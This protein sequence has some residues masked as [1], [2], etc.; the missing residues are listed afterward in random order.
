MSGADSFYYEVDF[1]DTNNNLVAAY[2]SAV[3]TNLSCSSP[4]VDQWNLLAIT[5]QMQIA[6]G[7]SNTG[8]VVGS[9]SNASV[10]VPAQTANAIFKAVLVQQN[11]ADLGSIYFSGANIGFLASPV[12]P[13]LSAINHLIWSHFARMVS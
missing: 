6:G 2:E 13:S 4:S 1:L 10:V 3:L 11:A 5:N 8:V 7:I 9:V 12:S